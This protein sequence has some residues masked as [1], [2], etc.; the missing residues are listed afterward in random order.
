MVKK[1][2]KNIN[3]LQVLAFSAQN[4]SKQTIWGFILNGVF[5]IALGIFDVAD[6]N[7]KI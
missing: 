7:I 4:I 6:K 2:S 3:F 5:E 1:L